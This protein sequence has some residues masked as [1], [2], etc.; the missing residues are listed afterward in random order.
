MLVALL[1]ATLHATPPGHRADTISVSEI[2]KGMKGFGLTVFEG[3]KPE[4]FGVTVIDILKNFRPH[5]DLILVNTEHPRLEVA[6]IVAGMSG[7]PIFFDGR[8]AGAYAYGW[9]FG[10]EPVAG[11]TPI[12][13]M[14]SDMDRPLPKV[15]RG[16]PLGLAPGS[17]P[18]R[19]APG[20]S[21]GVAAPELSTPGQAIGERFAPPRSTPPHSKQ[22]PDPAGLRPIAT[23]LFLAGMNGAGRKLAEQWLGPLGFDVMDSGG[24]ARSSARSNDPFENGGA[25]GVELIS[26]DM[27]AMGIGTVTRVEGDRLV[28]FGHPMMEIGVT[29]LPTSQARVLWF[30]ASTQRSFKIGESV[31]KRGALVNDR[32]ASI[33]VDQKAEAPTVPVR[34]KIVG[35]PGAPRTEWS[36]SVAH[37]PFLTPTLLGMAV[38]SALTSTAAERREVTYSITSRVRVRGQPEVQIED[39]GAGPSGTPDSG[40]IMQSALLAAVGG[41]FS[42]PW[43]DLELEGVDVEA[44][45]TFDQE[46]TLLRGAELLEPEIEPGEPARVRLWLEPHNQKV[47]PLVITVPLPKSLTGQ[48]VRIQIRPGYSVPRVKPAPESLRDMVQN[49]AEPS[50]PPRSLVFSVENGESGVAYRGLV[51]DSL[52]PGAA[53]RLST[54]SSA[55]GPL[56]FRSMS[57]QIET[58]PYYIVGS[59]QVQVH[60]KSKL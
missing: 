54:T 33:V 57:H 17:S 9:S 28:A 14:L 34:L 20:A 10:A 18:A 40:Q 21:G 39:F 11:V 15:L 53:D 49:L 3:T 16:L 13:N 46:V 42:N 48:D 4:R 35:E 6:K 2:K 32:Q 12:A 38:S 41:L 51:V 45:L 7:S 47:V 1:G 52:P 19:R 5:Q 23:P 22:S 37:D 31:G 30:M 44:R 24:G 59:S 50:Y 27:S 26:G 55:L 58:M 36:F 25:I 8:M 43:Q 60:V 29:S 56:E